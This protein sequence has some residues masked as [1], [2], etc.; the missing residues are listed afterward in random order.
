MIKVEKK[1]KSFLKNFEIQDLW[2]KYSDK[3]KE[4]FTF[5]DKRLGTKSRLDYCFMSEKSD[6]YVKKYT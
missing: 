6:F 3:S 2:N 5:H 4:G 1:L